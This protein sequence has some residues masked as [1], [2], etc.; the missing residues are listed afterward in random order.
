[1]I[2]SLFEHQFCPYE[3]IDFGRLPS[4]GRQRVLE[5]LESLNQSYGQ[6][7]VRLEHKGLRAAQQVGV[8]RAGELS[9]EILPK[10]DYTASQQPG[11]N[12]RSQNQNGRPRLAL[13]AQSAARNLL[14]MLSYAYDLRISPQA[15]AD[16]STLDGDWFELLTRMFA[17]QLYGQILSGISHDYQTREA[18][19]PVLRGR[20]DV[21][22][23][24]LR[25]FHQRHQF[26]VIYDDYT[27]DIPMNQVFRFVV[28]RLYEVSQDADNQALLHDLREWFSSVSLLP[29]APPTLLDAVHFT[30]LNERFLPVFNLARLF[31]S[32]SSI[33]LR[34]GKQ[35]LFA[36]VMDMNRLFQQF[37]A[38]FLTRHRK[39]VLPATW[40]DIR[41]KPQGEDT[42]VFL[43]T[44][45]GQNL[46]R[47]RPDLL[48]MRKGQQPPLLIADTKYKRLET[49]QRR[50]VIA[51]ED[52]YQMLAYR[53]RLGCPLGLLIYPQ[54]GE[55]GP[56]RKLVDIESAAMHLLVSTI[57]I[58]TPLEKPAAL[59]HEFKNILEWA[60][61]LPKSMGT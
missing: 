50:G 29:D 26:D 39:A 3:E 59:I 46:L 22:R 48:F 32:G 40:M 13:P 35:P 21:Q 12:R 58:H 43:A 24:A 23:Q 18:T 52:V 53:T 27:P 16:L 7:I 42:R 34:T 57:N 49:G 11:S 9:I 17:V 31:L 47:L 2:L 36:F 51:E 1:M 5:E 6:D 55:E 10:I 60:A 45:E 54:S 14:V 61:G 37:V 41:I 38:A 56:I 19:L 15:V 20:W 8:V 25:H 28:E 4:S 44:S 30:R 33:Y